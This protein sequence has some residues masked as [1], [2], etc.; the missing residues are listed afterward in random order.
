IAAK[1]ANGL[2]DRRRD[3]GCTRTMTLPA[4][5]R[6]TVVRA[7]AGSCE[8]LASRTAFLGQEIGAHAIDKCAKRCL[9]LAGIEC[10]AVRVCGQQPQ[11]VSEHREL[12]MARRSV[13]EQRLMTARS[14][15]EDSAQPLS[16]LPAHDSGGQTA[17][18]SGEIA[19]KCFRRHEPT[20]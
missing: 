10:R 1:R 11:I 18:T 8:S 16:G 3:G 17:R 7:E 4:V 13:S 2:G 20:I 15:A 9:S 12:W 14:A 19:T 5:I 6:S